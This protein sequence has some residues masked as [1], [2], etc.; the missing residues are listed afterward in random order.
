M[1]QK[2]FFIIFKGLSVEQIK[3]MF[4]EGES[5]TFKQRITFKSKKVILILMVSNNS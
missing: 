4:W 5:P 2:E 1:K 3:Q